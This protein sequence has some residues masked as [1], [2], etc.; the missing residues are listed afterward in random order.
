MWRYKG[1][2]YRNEHLEFAQHVAE[3]ERKRA[4]LQ[5]EELREEARE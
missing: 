3:E 4:Q 1:P 5:L 2:T